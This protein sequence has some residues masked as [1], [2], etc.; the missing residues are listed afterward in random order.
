M[1]PRV[2]ASGLKFPE[3][4]VYLGDG[5]VAVAEMQGG[6]VARVTADGTVTRFTG[7]GGGPN[8]A[9]LGHDGAIYVANNGGLSARTDGKGYWYAE[10]QFDGRVQR[11]DPDGTVTTVADQ[12]PGE[13]PHRPN[14]LC[15]GPDGRLYV[16]DSRNWEDMRNLQPGRIVAIAPDGAVA[17][18]AEVPAMPNGIAFGPSGDKL[19]V[20]QTLTRKI[21]VYPW[22][23]TAGLGEPE[24]FCQLPGGSRTGSVSTRTETCTCAA[25]SGTPSTCSTRRDNYA[26]RSRPNRVRSP[27]TAASVTGRCTSRIRC[28]GSWSRTTWEW[29]DCRCM[30]EAGDEVRAHVRDPGAAT[31]ARTQR[32]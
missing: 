13:A 12:L 11:I 18:L 10:E 31:M 22:S 21:L 24:V 1:T 26:A 16:T 25:A 19:F 3:G 30:K 2:V 6:S 23:A 20:A 8:G 29:P 32:L 27:P 14:D 5:V 4:P 17:Q 28:S 9:A 7:L 15:F